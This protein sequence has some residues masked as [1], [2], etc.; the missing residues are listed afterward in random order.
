MVFNLDCGGESAF[1]DFDS[2][3]KAMLKTIK[4]L[5]NQQKYSPSDSLPEINK[6]IN[7]YFKPIGNIIKTDLMSFHRVDWDDFI[8]GSLVTD[9]CF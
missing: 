9:K 2:N 6:E 3:Q 5:F 1:I 7:N 8:L 4:D